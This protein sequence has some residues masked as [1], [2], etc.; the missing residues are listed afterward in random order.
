M[1]LWQ[2]PGVDGVVFT[3]SK[4]VGL[5]IHAGISAPLDQAVPAGAGRQERGDRHRQRG[6]RRGGRGR[7]AL[8]VQPAEPEV[9]RHVP[10]VRATA[11][12]AA[13][14]IERL[15]EKTRAIR[16]GDPTERDVFFGPVINAARGR[17]ATSA[18]WRR[19]GRRAPSL[20]G[21]A[22]LRGGVFDQGHFVAPTIARLPLDSSLYREELFVP[23]LAVGEVERPRRGARA[24]PT[25][26]STASPPASSP[27]I[28]RRSSGSSTRSRPA[29]ATPTSAPA[30]RPVPGP[31]RSRSADGRA[32]ARP[33]RAGAGRTTSRSSLREQSR[34][35]IET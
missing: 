17:R 9:Q 23:F 3:G 16:M 30:R 2:H 4:A 28:Q 21:G 34:T 5:R 11:T 13:P 33:A 14:F 29:S 15:L 6:S 10:G 7:H 24:R 20:L 26:P 22:R 18:P 19:L 8:G 25:R 35:V 31:A 27:A 12:V 1:P 32:R